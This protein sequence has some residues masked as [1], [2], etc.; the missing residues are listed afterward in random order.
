MEI[1]YC[2]KVVETEAFK[3]GV[4]YH[5]ISLKIEMEDH[6]IQ[7]ER[8]QEGSNEPLFS[9]NFGPFVKAFLPFLISLSKSAVEEQISYSNVAYKLGMSLAK[10]W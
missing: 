1:T 4:N 9:V 5:Q 10:S 3:S 2:N 7:S 8:G 6:R